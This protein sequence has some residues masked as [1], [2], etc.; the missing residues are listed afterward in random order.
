M[1]QQRMASCPARFGL[2]FRGSLLLVPLIVANSAQ[3]AQS[4]ERSLEHLRSGSPF[5]RQRSEMDL[6]GQA[7]E[8]LVELARELTAPA[9]L[10]R[11]RVEKIFSERL[12][13]FLDRLDTEF[14]ALTL[15]GREWRLLEQRKNQVRA[16]E[17]YRKAIEV[18][19]QKDP[20]IA[21]KVRVLLELEGLEEIQGRSATSPSGER[22]T[23]EGVERIKTL[24]GRRQEWRQDPEFRAEIQQLVE[25]ARNVDPLASGLDYTELEELRA[26]ELKERISEREPRVER[27]RAQ[28]DA[29]GLAGINRVLARI[30]GAQETQL[31]LYQSLVTR[32]VEKFRGD[33]LRSDADADT[34]DRNRYS[35][36][37]IWSWELGRVA[38]SPPEATNFLERHLAATVADLRAPE[39][40]VQERAAQELFLLGKRGFDAL[41]EELT[42]KEGGRATENRFLAGLLRWRVSPSTYARVGI[43]FSDFQELPFRKKRR[44]VFDYA[45]VA[46]EKSIPTLRAIVRTDDLEP[47][48]FVKLAA[49][50]ALAGLRDLSGYTY[51]L[52]T[53]PDMTVK[54]PEVSR[55]LLIIQA[56]EFIREKQYELAVQELQKVLEEDPFDFR[57]NYHLGF[58]YLL[59]KNFAKSIRHFEIARRIHPKDELTL[60]NLACA[61]ALHG[62]MSDEAI[63][64]LKASVEA[65][66]NDHR[67]MERDPDLDSVRDTDG[68]KELID[69]LRGN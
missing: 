27:M 11:F 55:E 10:Y 36:S 40:L 28:L 65:G 34:F 53:H 49:A 16:F 5:E 64:A 57:A 41:T 24:T 45:R 8:G 58:A 14:R 7:E 20:D 23:P 2:T 43:D 30:P 6:R 68:F 39:T 67:H 69:S 52:E 18:W 12:D 13:G 51:L 25:L 29:Y 48:F 44:K 61:Y 46:Q 38:P 42:R 37:L 50:K 17:T 63:E 22:L 32:G 15:D 33:L 56:Y 4:L 60:Y 47:S 1:R 26:Q 19:G 59:L 21:N 54:K 3:A 62:D 35:Q 9:R 31:K 66:F